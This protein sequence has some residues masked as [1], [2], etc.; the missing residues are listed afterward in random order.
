MKKKY[1]RFVDSNHNTLFHI[2]DG[3]NIIITRN[4]GTEFKRRC[5]FLDEVHTE[6]EGVCFHICEWADIMERNGA[7]YHQESYIPDLEFYP[8]RFLTPVGEVRPPYYVLDRARGF[9]IAYAPNGAPGKKYCVFDCPPGERPGELRVGE[10]RMFAGSLKTIE[11]KSWGFN[12]EK[13]KAVTGRKPRMRSE[14]ER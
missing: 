6:I 3:T 11:P 5:R 9:A 14:P 4:D 2:E 7:T 10:Y 12:V 8:R 13:I 1:I